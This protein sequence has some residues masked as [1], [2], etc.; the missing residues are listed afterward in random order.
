MIVNYVAKKNI[1]VILLSTLHKDKQINDTP[2]KKPNIT[3]DYNAKKGAVDTLDPLVNTYTCKRKT[4][5]WPLI[6]FYN[7]NDISAYKAF[8]LFTSIN[9]NWNS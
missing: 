9:P 2:D 6:I 3:L 7:I 4:N 8:V 5:R 1:N